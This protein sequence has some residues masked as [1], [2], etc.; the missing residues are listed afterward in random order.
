MPLMNGWTGGQYSLF[1]ILLGCYLLQHI[2]FLLPWS[3]DVFSSTGLVSGSAATAR[4]KFSG[5][6][7]TRF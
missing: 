7:N 5:K 1:R 4:S 3:A 6:N 2:A